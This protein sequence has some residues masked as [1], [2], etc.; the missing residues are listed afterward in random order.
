[1]T[2]QYDSIR[3]DEGF[4]LVELAVV[5]IIIGLLVGGILKGQEMIANTQV[6]S[7]VAQI[8][9]VDAAVGTFRDMY[10][11]FPGDMQNA[12]NRI[13][14]CNDGV[15]NPASNG[16]QRLEAAPLNAG[17]LA[18]AESIAFFLQLEAADLISGLD[19]ANSFLD[20]NIDGNEFVPGYTAGGAAIGLLANPRAGHYLSIATVNTGNGVGLQ[21]LEAARI[22]RK[23]DDGDPTTGSAGGDGGA[24]CGA[25]G[26]Y[27]EDSQADACAMLI[28][29]QG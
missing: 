18:D 5:M 23:V 28:R 6:T 24:A 9:A 17:A 1:M 2:T 20:T 11:S 10:D 8:K 3:N 26:A 4:T 12:N 7:T 14:N 21:P 16:N 25:A 27:D 29:I 15:C 19:A 22:D 13:T